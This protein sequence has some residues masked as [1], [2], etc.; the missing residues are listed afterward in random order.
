MI[1]AL[2]LYHNGRSHSIFAECLLIFHPEKKL[3]IALKTIL[4]LEVTAKVVLVVEII[5]ADKGMPLQPHALIYRHVHHYLQWLLVASLLITHCAGK[6][7]PL[8]PS[9][10]SLIG[11]A[12]RDR[13]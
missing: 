1:R 10:T 4:V 5:L 7:L 9:C 13:S 2:A 3:A 12:I 6:T 8:L 11:M